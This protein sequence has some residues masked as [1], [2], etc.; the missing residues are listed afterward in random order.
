M[1]EAGFADAP[2]IFAQIKAH[3]E[4]LV[5]RPLGDIVAHIDRFWVAEDAAGR[6]VGTVAWA[7]WPAPDGA[8]APSVEIQSLCVAPEWRGRGLGRKL[9]EAAVGR[10]RELNAKQIVV[11]TFAPE[12]FGRLGFVPVSKEKLMYKLF[13]GCMH[14]TRYASPY[15]C[16]EIAMALGGA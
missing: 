14:C 10:I 9:V 3:P 6:V 5:P 11:L 12:F 4:E 15:T 13:N 7:I 8:E 1:R 2:E 16:P